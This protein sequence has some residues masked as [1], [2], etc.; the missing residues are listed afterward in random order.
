MFEWAGH[1]RHQPFTFEDGTQAIMPAM[2]KIDGQDFAIG[3]QID[4]G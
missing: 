4:T 2:H 3:N 1:L